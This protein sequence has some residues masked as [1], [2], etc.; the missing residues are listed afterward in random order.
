MEVCIVMDNE[1]MSKIE[2]MQAKSQHAFNF[3]L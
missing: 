2:G 1:D 3:H